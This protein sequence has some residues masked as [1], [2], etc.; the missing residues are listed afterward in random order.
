MRGIDLSSLTYECT[1][2]IQ[3]YNITLIMSTDFRLDNR[4]KQQ[5]PMNQHSD[6]VECF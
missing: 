5:K 6:Q 2:D 3:V 1:F 4:S